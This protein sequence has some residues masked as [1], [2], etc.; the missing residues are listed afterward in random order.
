MIK[1]AASYVWCRVEHRYALHGMLSC[2]WF[3]LF[4]V[5]DLSIMIRYV[6][7]EENKLFV[8]VNVLI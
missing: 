4:E 6:Q 2:C 7:G 1:F 8:E 3:F 5:T